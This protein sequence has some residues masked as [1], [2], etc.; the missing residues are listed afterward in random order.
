MLLQVSDVGR[1]G[2]IDLT[3][4]HPPHPRHHR[5]E[6]IRRNASS[7]I[8]R[9][10]HVTTEFE[11]PITELVGKHAA[12]HPERVAIEDGDRRLT[13]GDLD[14]MAASIAAGLQA[15][16]LEDEEPVGVCL[17]RSWQAVC[18][19]L[20]ILRAGAAYVPVDPTHPAA[21]Q[22]AAAGARRCEDGADR[23]GPRRRAAAR[24]ETTRRGSPGGVRRPGSTPGQR[25]RRP[26]RLVLFTSGSTGTPKGVEIS[27]AQPRQPDAVRRR[28]DPAG[29]HGCSMSF[30]SD[31]TFRAGDLGGFVNGG[32]LVI[33]RPGGRTRPA[34]QLVAERG[35][36]MVNLDRASARAD[37]RRAAGPRLPAT[38]AGARRR[39]LPAG[40]GTAAG[41][42]SRRC[43]SEQIRAR[44]RPRSPPRASR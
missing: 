30:R 8:D 28:H 24:R 4:Q 41:G 5:S 43:G 32:R 10:L 26:A 36:T 33:G 20:G 34:G 38:I 13:Y 16:D 18:A 25:R 1:N 7:N 11:R 9:G 6:D 40:G 44:P 35:V 19:F 23:P 27:H 37:R 39:A 31:S 14:A 17:P 3:S 12:E 29:R 21:R 2:A 42:P 22:R 15:G